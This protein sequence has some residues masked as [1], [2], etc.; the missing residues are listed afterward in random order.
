M[1]AL[2][3]IEES[4]VEFSSKTHG[5]MHA[6][7]HDAHTAMLLGSAKVLSKM[8]DEIN[9]NIKFFFQEGEETFTGAKK[10]IKDGGMNGVDACFGLHC[11]PDLETGYVNIDSGYKM[12]GCDTI[13]VK[14]EGVSGHGSSPHLAKD[15]IYPACTFVSGLQAI[16]TKN[17]DPQEPVVLTV[18]K[19]IGGTKA[20]IIPKYTNLDISMRYFNP[21][22][23]EIVHQSIKRHAKAIAEAYEINVDVNIEESAISLYNDEELSIIAKNSAKKILGEGKTVSGPKLMGSE[24]FP[25]YLKYAKGVYAYLGYNNKEKDSIYYPHHEKFKIDEECLKYG[26]ALH[27]QFALDFLNEN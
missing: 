16:A 5:L 7:G 14:F 4:G 18:G 8:K 10:I 3:I 12:A 26:V 9:G 22:V 2:P 17:I 11:M 24:D 25:Y 19:F 13:Y 23:R 6:C 27:V 15:T 1:D 21:K 20:N